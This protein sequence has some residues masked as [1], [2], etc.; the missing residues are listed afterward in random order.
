MA[1]PLQVTAAWMLRRTAGARLRYRTTPAHF[2]TSRRAPP[3]RPALRIETRRRSSR[4]IARESRNCGESPQ[5]ES[6][7]WRDVGR[8]GLRQRAPWRKKGIVEPRGAQCAYRW[9]EAQ[10]TARLSDM[11]ARSGGLP[12]R[13][14]YDVSSVPLSAQLAKPV[15]FKAP[16]RKK[17]ARARVYHQL[18]PTG[19]RGDRFNLPQRTSLAGSNG[20]VA[21]GISLAI[22]RQTPMTAVRRSGKKASPPLTWATRRSSP[23]FLSG[24]S[25]SKIPIV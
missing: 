10:A 1:A 16:V 4:P 23:G 13:G 20:N 15:R 17:V 22:C 24:S 21:E 14:S 6:D 5:V 11:C 8:F 25:V 12:P 19:S 7:R 2:Q 9:T 18:A 3:H